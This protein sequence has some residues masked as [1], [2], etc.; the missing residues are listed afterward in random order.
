MTCVV[1]ISEN[2][3]VYMGADSAGVDNDGG[4]RTRK[5]SKIFSK[6]SFIIGYDGSFRLGQLIKYGFEIPKILKN[7]DIFEYMVNDFVPLL[8][9]HLITNGLHFKDDGDIVGSLLVG[10]KGRILGIE[11]DFNVSELDCRYNSIGIG[12]DVALGSLHSTEYT[13]LPPFDRIEMALYA[14]SEFCSGVRPP[15]SMDS[16]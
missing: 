8:R 6:S 13:E 16:L 2:N 12:S 9:N 15:F 10:I 1:A 14:A 3:I 7:A 5:D 11:S 4:I